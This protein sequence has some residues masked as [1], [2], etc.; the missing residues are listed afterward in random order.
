MKSLLT[1]ESGYTALDFYGALRSR[2]YDAHI[3]KVMLMIMF[4]IF[5]D[6]HILKVML[7]IVF[8]ISLDAHKLLHAFCWPSVCERTGE[9]PVVL[10]QF[11]DKVHANPSFLLCYLESVVLE[12]TDISA[13]P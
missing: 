4:L 10:K 3:L 11:V 1:C 6:G 5:L 7:M 12:C 13:L 2:T 9:C 8:L